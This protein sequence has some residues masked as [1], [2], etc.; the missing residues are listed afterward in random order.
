MFRS[1]ATTP[2]RLR[3]FPSTSPRPPRL[4]TPTP[5]A[6]PIRSSTIRSTSGA[7]RS[8]F[9]PASAATPALVACQAENNIPIVGKDQVATRP[10]DALDPHGSL[11]REAGQVHRRGRQRAGDAGMGHGQPG[12]GPATGGLR[13][14]RVR[15]LRNRLP[16]QRHRPHRGRPQRDGL[17]PLHRH[18]LLREQLPLQGPSLQLLR[19]QQA[20]P[21]HR[22]QPLQGPLGEKTG[23]RGR[24]TFRR[25]RTSRSACAV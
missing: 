16:G 8:T 15:S 23:R 13:A 20:Q 3:T 12:A 6:R 18:P 17:Q 22:P 14:V 4:S 25:T 21:A 19:L 7:C 2:T 11:F 5:R 10:R 24:R 9:P 1:R